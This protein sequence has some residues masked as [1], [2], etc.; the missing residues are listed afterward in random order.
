MFLKSSNLLYSFSSTSAKTS[1]AKHLIPTLT[2]ESVE[3]EDYEWKQ[4]EDGKWWYG[5][6]TENYATGHVKI[7]GQWYTFDDEG[8]Y[9]GAYAKGSKS[10]SKTGMGITNEDGSELV[11]KTSS[12]ALLTPL[13][14]GDM[15]FT[16]D[17]SQ[18]LWEIAKG[19]VPSNMNITMPNI[20]GSSRQNVTANNQISIELPNV[21]NY[22]EFKK[23]MKNDSEMEK[24]WQEITIGQMMG[25]NSLKKNKY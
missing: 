23:A 18:R 7:D 25:N 3:D 2:D 5:S 6:S 16:H 1:V 14:Q 8:W 21:K 17:M 12:G 11:W 20:S 4:S 15:V 13:G 24:F 22:D 19:N 9:L 10:I